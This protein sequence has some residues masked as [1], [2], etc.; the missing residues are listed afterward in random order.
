MLSVARPDDGVHSFFTA[1]A[2]TIL[3]TLLEPG[4]LS[5]LVAPFRPRRRARR[6]DVATMLWLG[7]FAAA[8]AAVRSME[9][10]LASACAAV[11]GGEAVPLRGRTLTQSGWSRAKRRMPLGLLRRVWRHWVGVARELAGPAAR[12]AGLRLVALD[13]K[14]LTV[15]EALWGVFG[16]KGPAGRDGP[17]QGELMVAY[18][19][20]VRVPLTMTLSRANRSEHVLAPKV[21]GGLRS[22]SLVLLDAGFY[23]IALF[24]RVVALGHEFLARM[25][26]NCRPRLLRRLGEDDGLYELR[27]SRYWKDVPDVPERMVVRVVRVHWKGFRPVRLVT[28]LLDAEAFPHADLFELY[29]RRWHVETFFRELSSDVGFEHWHTRTVKGLYVELLFTLT[30]VTVVRAAMAEAATA[31]GVLPGALSFGRGAGACLRS[32]CRVAKSPP[33]RR[34][35]LLAELTHYLATLQVDIRPGRRFERDTQKRRALSRRNKLQ[36]LEANTHA[37]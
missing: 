12:F 5:R 21:L 15:P 4:T 3:S 14:T 28:S 7:V 22:P 32:W 36:A 8:N 30:Y 35:D 20:C 13:K 10:I 6:F 37:A 34:R 11:E 2:R 29:H 31:A 27:A 26:G 23:S 16:S 9:E 17:A 24:A 25:R 1:K 19:V 18:D 33:T